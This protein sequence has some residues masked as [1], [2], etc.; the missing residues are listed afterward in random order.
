MA[1]G[2][3]RYSEMC[4]CQPFAVFHPVFV[5]PRVPIVRS[6]SLRDG[7]CLG[8]WTRHSLGLKDGG[9]ERFKIGAHW[10]GE[11]GFSCGIRGSAGDLAATCGRTCSWPPF[12]SWVTRADGPEHPTRLS[13]KARQSTFTP[14]MTTSL[15]ANLEI[16][17]L[18]FL[19][20]GS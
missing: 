4:S 7:L 10:I 14:S 11:M 2:P 1:D 18:L 17:P 13:A 12:R 19:G 6:N 20:L 3:G 8:R 15:V 9:Q 5:D 16:L